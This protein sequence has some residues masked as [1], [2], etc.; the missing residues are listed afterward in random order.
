MTP[1][2]HPAC[3]GKESLRTGAYGASRSEWPGGS[4]HRE[5]V[6]CSWSSSGNVGKHR[7]SVVVM[8]AVSRSA[9]TRLFIGHTAERVI[10][11]LKCDVLIV[12]PRRFKTRVVPRP[13]LLMTLPP[14]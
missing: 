13:R 11:A 3:S 10:D 14:F 6:L 2:S 5:G 4:G 7:A 8:G 9:L 12:K 1:G